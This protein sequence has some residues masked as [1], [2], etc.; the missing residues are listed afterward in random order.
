M[1]VFTRMMEGLAAVGA[2]PET[3]RKDAT[4][5]KAQCMAFSLRAKEGV[6]L[7]DRLHEGGLKRSATQ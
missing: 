7:P 1:G 4:Y 2:K 5:L 3:I 6:R